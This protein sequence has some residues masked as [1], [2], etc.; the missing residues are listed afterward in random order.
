MRINLS[1]LFS[2]IFII[3]FNVLT[4][5]QKAGTPIVTKGGKQ[6]YAHTVQKGETVY[7]LSRTY[8]TTDKVIYQENPSA[9]SGIKVGEIIY[10][11]VANGNTNKKPEF[12]N[13]Q[14]IKSSTKHTVAKGETLYGISRKYNITVDEL[15]KANPE[16]DNGL[17]VGA[18]LTIPLI[19][20]V[21]NE[22]ENNSSQEPEMRED[23][24]I[25][26][27][28]TYK[29]PTQDALPDLNTCL[30]NKHTK[31]EYNIAVLVPLNSALL[32]VP[33]SARIA[34]QYYTGLK[35]AMAKYEPIKAKIN[36]NF[37]S[38]GS[39]SNDEESKKIVQNS[40]FQKSDL[41]IGPL[42]TSEMTPILE[43][44][45]EKQVPM[46][47]P[48]SRGED[49]LLDN[50]YVF[51]ASPS[52]VTYAS[53]VAS[54][55]NQKY[56]NGKVILINTGLKKDSIFYKSLRDTLVLKYKFDSVSANRNLVYLPK[57][58]NAAAFIKKDVPNIC[59]YPT[60]KEISMNTFLSG[61]NKF[62]KDND[63][64]ILG[65]ES[66]FNFRNFD[67]EH[68]SNCK[69]TIPVVYKTFSWDS[70]YTSFINSYKSE[71]GT[72]PEFYAYRGYELACL[73]IDMLEKYG[74]MLAPCA[75]YDK[76]K[77]LITP[78]A[79]RKT[80][81][82]GYENTGISLMVLDKYSIKYESY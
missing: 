78:F 79:W 57:G 2:I 14:D 76:N 47:S 74:S 27:P 17:K 22:D 70:T 37:F 43:Y 50:P 44:A 75:I 55:L 4:Y 56:K 39:K 71:F 26:R 23:V 59:V 49:I 8:N 32:S 52:E 38:T 15:V 41:I 46:I 61:M 24:V 81:G 33:R 63:L 1:V 62:G 28:A 18:V 34:Y 20:S 53:S 21:V 29:T 68:L 69:V 10:I 11:P 5:A 45:K 65:D 13:K 16:V 48:F 54:M 30:D 19:S 7:G 58:G 40:T 80:P 9:E 3:G 42:Y 66:W 64:S 31:L 25:T 36:W 51:K 60:N 6:Y 35:L 73:S 77:Y 82:G 12:S 72:E 67:V